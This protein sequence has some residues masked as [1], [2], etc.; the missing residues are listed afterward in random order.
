MKKLIMQAL[1][2]FI[3]ATLTG[4]VYAETTSVVEKE[5]Q[6]AV[7]AQKDKQLK[8]QSSTAKVDKQKTDAPQI[9]TKTEESQGRGLPK[10]FSNSEG[11]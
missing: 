9:G 4:Y 10:A 8:K 6:P 3:L 5:K 1:S 2:V 7:T 11:Q